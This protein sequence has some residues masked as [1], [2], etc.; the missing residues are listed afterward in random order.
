[1]NHLEYEKLTIYEVESLHKELLKWIATATGSLQLDFN[2]VKIIDIAA[3][4][5][6]LSAQ[7][8]CA[9]KSCEF[10]LLNVPPEVNQTMQTAGCA[11]LFKGCA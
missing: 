7:K 11:N 4:Q 5:L 3:I 10:E 8:S 9:E 2:R 1:M 6:L